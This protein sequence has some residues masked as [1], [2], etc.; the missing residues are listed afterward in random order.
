LAVVYIGKSRSRDAELL[1]IVM[2]APA[3]FAVSMLSSQRENAKK[4][5]GKIEKEA[6][7]GVE[8][9]RMRAREQNFKLFEK[10][11]QKDV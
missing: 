2:L 5:Q 6:N 8:V 11:L 1:E 10:A 3:T 4:R 7:D 9:E